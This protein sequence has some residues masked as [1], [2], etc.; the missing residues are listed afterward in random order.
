MAH[1]RWKKKK[2]SNKIIVWFARVLDHSICDGCRIGSL[3]LT[4]YFMAASIAI[5][6]DQDKT[7]RTQHNRST[8]RSAPLWWCI[9]IINADAGHEFQFQ[10]SQLGYSSHS[11][12][13]HSSTIGTKTHTH[14]PFFFFWFFF[15]KNRS[16]RMPRNVDDEWVV[17]AV[18][19][20]GSRMWHV[21]M[22]T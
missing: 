9:M 12:Q 19:A 17:C 1:H 10:F 3:R 6:V 18:I 7:C 13:W 22:R 5:F 14:F 21:R 2:N 8:A 11:V 15:F 16:L 4:S 20:S